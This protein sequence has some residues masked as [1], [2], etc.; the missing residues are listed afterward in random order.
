MRYKD[1]SDLEEDMAQLTQEIEWVKKQ[2][3]QIMWEADEIGMRERALQ[4]RLTVLESDL[5]NTTHTLAELIHEE[6]LRK[7]N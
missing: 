4:S 7:A 6:E 2:L 5:D 3:V 1:Q